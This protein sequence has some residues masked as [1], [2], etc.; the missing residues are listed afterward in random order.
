[1]IFVTVGTH[2]QGFERLI[3]EVDDL[4]GKNLIRDNFLI[5]IGNAK[6]IPKN[7]KW[8][9]FIE[10]EKFDGLCKKANI[11]IT[12]GGVGSIITPLKYNKPIIAVP[13]LKKFNEH[14]DDHQLQIVRELG[15]QKKVIVVYDI[16]KLKFAIFKAKKW[17][18]K[19]L[20]NRSKI[21]NLIDNFIKNVQ[22]EL[23]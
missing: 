9:H 16:G 21:L 5:Q 4:A 15:K 23:K 2:R 13:R 10:P 20:S 1:M 18:P 14:T 7:C 11:V 19:N 17:K 8:F 6:Y 12:H 22:S 3:K